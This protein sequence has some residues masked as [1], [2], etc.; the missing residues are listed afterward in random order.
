M[1]IALTSEESCTILYSKNGRVVLKTFSVGNCA[2]GGI[3]PS[4]LIANRVFSERQSQCMCVDF[5]VVG[6]YKCFCGGRHA[7]EF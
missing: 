7:A 2:R 6:N 1:V 5:G 3:F 4:G